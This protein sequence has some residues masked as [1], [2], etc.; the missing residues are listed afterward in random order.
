MALDL[1][2]AVSE[3]VDEDLE[4]DILHLGLLLEAALQGVECKLS[5]EFQIIV[6]H[7]LQ[8]EGDK[9]G[10][11]L[12]KGVLEVGLQDVLGRFASFQEQGVLTEGGQLLIITEKLIT[13][14]VPQVVNSKLH[15]LPVLLLRQVQQCL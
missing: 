13:E 10:V 6:R 5:I 9:L 7:R 4:D 3:L 14:Q 2:G 15:L 8:D 12:F 1:L 11:E